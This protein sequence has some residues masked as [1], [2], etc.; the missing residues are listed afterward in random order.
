MSNQSAVNVVRDQYSQMKGW[1][2]GTMEGV[3]EELAHYD[4]PGLPVSIGA[5]AAHVVTGIDFFLLGLAA[6]KAPLLTSSFSEKSGISSPP[7]AGGDWVEWAS[8]VKVDL[9]AMHAYSNAVFAAVDDYLASL[10]D[11][12]LYTEKEF[13]SAGSQTV[14]WA[15]NILI[16]NTYSHVGEISCIKGMQGLKGYPF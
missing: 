11:E 2:D 12:D 4:P 14:L 9:P 3:N 13:G 5:Q 7:P 1:L 6:G 8:T 15:F 16:L 10:S